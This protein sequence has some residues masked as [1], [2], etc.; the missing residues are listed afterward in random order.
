[1]QTATF[2]N[3]RTEDKNF[4]MPDSWGNMD[5]RWDLQVKQA[6]EDCWFYDLDVTLLEKDGTVFYQGQKLLDPEEDFEVD[7]ALLQSYLSEKTAD[8]LDQ[9]TYD[10]DTDSF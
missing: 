1:M 6:G 10:L 8:W 7:H 9:L 2:L 3:V 4:L 5:V